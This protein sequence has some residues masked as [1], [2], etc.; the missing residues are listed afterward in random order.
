MLWHWQVKAMSS[1]GSLGA[2]E[3]LAE[4]A[5]QQDPAATE[6]AMMGF[7]QVMTHVCK[8]YTGG[9]SSSVS[10]LE[11]NQLAAS[12][13]YVLG[14]SGLTA[15]DRAL[16]LL[17][18]DDPVAVWTQRRTVLEQ[19]LV[20]LME[21]WQEAVATLP[22]IR[23]IA[24]RDTLTSIQQLPRTYDSFFA[25]HEIPCSIDYPLSIP[26]SEELQGL[27]YVQA[28]L[29]QLL[30]EARFLARFDLD[31]IMELIDS[32]CPDPCGLLINL[33]EPVFQAWQLGRISLR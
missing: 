15:P 5:A 10:E 21:L 30:E 22:P 28:W 8:L 6:R 32:W 2:M 1:R 16:V 3:G 12:V 7:A 11:G 4:L 9:E 19:R 13:L 18:A 33:Y 23:N 25:A 31:Q 20:P 14:G 27:Y 26:I 17:A 29:E 24:L